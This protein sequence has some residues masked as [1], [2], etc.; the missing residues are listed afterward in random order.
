MRPCLRRE[1][2]ADHLQIRARLWGHGPETLEFLAT[3]LV[4]VGAV[5]Q[6][7]RQSAGAHAA[8]GTVAAQAITIG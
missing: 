8:H 7:Q 5:G 2:G 3:V 6:V 4:T 1:A